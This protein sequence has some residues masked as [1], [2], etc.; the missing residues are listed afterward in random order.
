MPRLSLQQKRQENALTISQSLPSTNPGDYAIER[1]DYS[2]SNS[3]E[4]LYKTKWWPTLMRLYDCR[5]ALCGEDRDGIELD[6]FWIPKSH[7]GNL[8]LRHQLANQIINNGVPLCTACNRHKQESI[9]K[10]NDLQL[11]KIAR[12]N[13]HMTAMINGV[14]AIEPLARLH[15]YQPGDERRALGVDDLSLMHMAQMYKSNPRPDALDA[16]K[17]E[18]D[19]YLLAKG[20]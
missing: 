15:R 7:G 20:A 16:L 19:V 8:L 17:R 18:I 6:H 10:L 5:C 3:D 13:R 4:R 14:Y 12:T 11:E 2:R 1:R 9:I